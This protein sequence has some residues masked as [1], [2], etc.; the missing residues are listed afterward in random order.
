M[1]DTGTSGPTTGAACG[2]QFSFGDIATSSTV[3]AGWFSVLDP[4]ADAQSAVD[5]VRTYV[6]SQTPDKLLASETSAWQAWQTAAPSGASALEASVFQQ[7][8]AM[9][10][11]A[12]VSASDASDGQVLAAI[13]PGDWNISW[14]RDMAYSTV[15][16]AR[17]GHAAEAKRAL[18]F[19]VGAPVNGGAFQ[20]YVGSP[21]QISVVRYYGNGSEWSDTNSDGPNVEF[22]GFGLFL[23][24]LQTYV[25]QT[26]DTASLAAWW[27]T[28]KPMVADVLASLQEP[29][30][31]ISP[32][33]SI[34]EVHWNGHES[35]F[36]Y[37]TLAAARGLCAASRLAARMG[38]TAF[39]TAYLLQGKLARDAILG[40]LR[41]PSG[42]IGQSVE[43]LASGNWLDAAVV[44]ALSFGLIDPH[45][46]TANATLSAI[47]AGLVPPSGRGFMRDQGGGTYDSAEWI[48][49]D[50]RTGRMLEAAG[51]GPTSANLFAWNVAQG[52][53]NFGILSE[54][55]DPVTGDYAGAAPMVGF[56]AGSYVL[57][58]IDRGQG[59]FP[60]C[61]DFASEPDL[62]SEAGSDGGHAVS[63]AAP[64]NGND[65]SVPDAGADASAPEPPSS[66]G[67]AMSTVSPRMGGS[68]AFALVAFLL[69][70]RRRRLSAL[71]AG[72]MAL[73]ACRPSASTQ[74]PSGCRSPGLR[75]DGGRVNR[76]GASHH[77]R[78]RW[79][80]P[81]HVF[82][83]TTRRHERGH[84]QRIGRVE[85]VL[86]TRRR[87]DAAERRLHGT[88]PA[89]ARVL[90]V[91]AHR[92]RHVAARPCLDDAQVRQRRGE[93]RSHRE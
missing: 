17:T 10:R 56:G 27:P 2:M 68:V 83:H 67:C 59:V 23:W 78:R 8:Q 87:D 1:D 15:A 26:N 63:D 14:V 25:D 75:P 46:G 65:A 84:R 50:L 92:R 29:T 12:Q 41:A 70:A 39:S 57:S 30:G 82:L 38:D 73:V 69:L 88:G 33:S 93:L 49:I 85:R 91:Q 20:S 35:H 74:P 9:L 61:D 43:A 60:S 16:L 5:A 3:W 42:A 76:R 6:G 34:W 32:D 89:R 54:L 55:H 51:Q 66:G 28:V 22:D 52:G 7:S 72:A 19:E 64:P 13:A 79:S 44:E 24:A 86:D 4:G 40:S 37:T 21:Y 53:D 45:K 71:G 58:L 36:A 11:M 80:V 62:P 81:D 90:R 18:A 77:R 31:L 48:F 47:E